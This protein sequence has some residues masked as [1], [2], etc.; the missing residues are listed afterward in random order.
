[1][2]LDFGSANNIFNLSTV[3]YYGRSFTD[4]PGA[5]SRWIGG[6]VSSIAAGN[7]NNSIQ[8]APTYLSTTLSILNYT[9]TA[10]AA[11]GTATYI[12]LSGAVPG[13]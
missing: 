4:A 11:G 10:L 8:L 13:L 1:V 6:A 7:G 9:S 5:A 3:S 12:Q 2:L